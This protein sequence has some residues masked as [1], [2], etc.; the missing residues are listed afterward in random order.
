LLSN[1]DM[2]FQVCQVRAITAHSAAALV[3]RSL[4][5]LIPHFSLTLLLS[6][7]FAHSH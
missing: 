5:S 1:H 3:L 6:L 4:V 2:A 7:T